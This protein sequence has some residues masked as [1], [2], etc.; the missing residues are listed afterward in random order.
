MSK[1]FEIDNSH[2]KNL[3]ES[4]PGLY[5]VLTKD[6]RIVTA[7]DA[8]L[9]ATMTK[10][11]EVVGHH[12]FE[13]FPDNPSDVHATGVQNL[14]A[15]LQRV[16][17]YQKADTM[18]IQK[19]D[20]RK[21]DGE[22]EE[23]YWSPANTPVFDYEGNLEYI[24]HS[25]EDVT[26]LVR[27]SEELRQRTGE[28]YGKMQLGNTREL[29]I[30]HSELNALYHQ[31]K[32]RDQA[33]LAVILNHIPDGIITIN[34]AGNIVT[35]NKAS[36]LIF[37]YSA[38]EVIGQNINMLMPEPYHSKHDGYM[39]H[40]ID[41]GEAKIIGKMNREVSGKRKDGSIFPIDIL[42]SNFM[43]DGKRHFSGI[44]RDVTERKK[45]ETT[46]KLL[47]SIVESSDDA[48]I[49][50]TLE[51]I[52]LSWNRGAEKVFGYTEQ[53]MIGKN[54]SVLIP[55]SRMEEESEIMAL[56]HGGKSVDHFETQRLTKSGKIIDVS[57]AIS[58]LNDSAGKVIG[59]SKV[60]RDITFRKK[61]EVQLQEQRKTLEIFTRALAHDLKEPMRTISAFTDMLLRNKNS[62]EKLETYLQYIQKAS[63]RMTML[64]ET[65]F[66]YTQLDAEERVIKEPCDMNVIVEETKD[67][68]HRLI[69]E[70]NAAIEV[71]GLLPHIHANHVHMLQVL[72]NLITNAI[73]HSGTN[74]RIH[75]SAKQQGENWCFAVTDN[76]PGIAREQLENIFMPFKRLASAKEEGAGL[77]LAICKK[78]IELHN[79]KIWCESEPDKGAT[80]LFSLPKKESKTMDATNTNTAKVLSINSPTAEMLASI[81]LVDDRKSD[82][83]LVKLALF[84]YGRL[85]C[86]MLVA[87]DGREALDLLRKEISAGR[88]VDL[89]LLDIN[90]PG[91]NGFE[92]MEAMRKDEQLKKIA[93]IMCTG[94]VYE[95]DKQR[96]KE[97]G[98]LDYIVKPPKF[99]DMKLMLERI[100]AISLCASGEGYLLQRAS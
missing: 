34:E 76:G 33:R 94:S 98:A 99:D 54:I 47:S 57:L 26:D 7:S 46:Q 49:S 45:S 88:K 20:I 52:I 8:Y 14:K 73:R 13:I 86:N 44:V 51:G 80:F 58:P 21:P 10:R 83:E 29:I 18:A 17:Q 100:P 89:I 35:F 9:R 69:Q 37:G 40:Y 43:L 95:K 75:I 38:E 53:E 92:M 11:E 1:K 84:E 78:I 93:V 23:R 77:G 36:E 56:L 15:S 42:V 82:I 19:Y 27:L 79:G 64:I 59:A 16:L 96:A 30:A 28:D 32:E 50:K 81:L 55:E 67:N 70:H 4:A 31:T 24:L 87:N 85:Q 41:T 90:M 25:A 39:K 68:L 5:L 97:L 61:A 74:V 66:L 48:I 63:A 65:V 60:A 72:Q 2:F 22:F 91:M 6:L 71:E 3:F 62:P 12:L